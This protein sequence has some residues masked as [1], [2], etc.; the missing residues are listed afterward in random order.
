MGAS[1]I[2]RQATLQAANDRISDAIAELPIFE[3]Y[4]F[5]LETL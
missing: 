1:R 3:H 5:D 2:L 4:S